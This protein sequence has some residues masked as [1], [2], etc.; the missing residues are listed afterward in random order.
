DRIERLPVT[1]ARAPQEYFRMFYVDTA[2][3]GTT[4]A[5]RCGLDYF[6]IRQVLFGSDMPFDAEGGSRYIRETIADLDAAGLPPDRRR[7]VDEGNLRRLV[8]EMKEGRR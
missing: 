5:I 7:M 4:H 2:L 3:F 6:P 1:L 8:A